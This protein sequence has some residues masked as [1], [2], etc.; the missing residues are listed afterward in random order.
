VAGSGVKL[1]ASYAQLHGQFGRIFLAKLTAQQAASNAASP[2]WFD[3]SLIRSEDQNWWR[4]PTLNI[5]P[6]SPLRKAFRR[7]P[8][9]FFV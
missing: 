3:I 2:R 5:R 4:T 1:V 8:L 6:L 7:T 9:S